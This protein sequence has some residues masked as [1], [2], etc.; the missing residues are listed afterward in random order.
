MTLTNIL[1]IITSIIGSATL[2]FHILLMVVKLTGVKSDILLKIFEKMS[3]N[4][5][6]LKR[7]IVIKTMRN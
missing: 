7:I 2:I 5:G 4:V 3:L 1:M 6:K